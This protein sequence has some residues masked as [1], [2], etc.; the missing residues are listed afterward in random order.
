M[1]KKQKRAIKIAIKKIWDTNPNLHKIVSKKTEKQWKDKKQRKNKIDGM[2]KYWNE[3]P[4]RRVEISEQFSGKNNHSYGKPLSERMKRIVSETSKKRWANYK[5]R[6]KHSIKMKEFYE[7]NPKERERV[8]ITLKQIWSNPEYKKMMSIKQKKRYENKYEKNKT[9]KATLK[10]WRNPEYREK[11]IKNT[12]EA[13]RQRPTSLEKQMIEI[14][15]KHNL[16]YRYTGNGSFLIGFKNPD[17]VNINGQKI[18]IEVLNDYIGHHP[19]DYEKNRSTHFAKYG[20][21]TIF[22][23]VKNNTFLNEKEV[24]EKIN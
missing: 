10:L 12:M 21:K 9:K 16:P 11:T 15:Q 19:L 24:L 2:K 18:C 5:N 7:N 14:I 22:F 4:E 20:W 8:S 23:R 6:K 1:S 13:L 17:F 3:H